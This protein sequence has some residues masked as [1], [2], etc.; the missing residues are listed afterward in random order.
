LIIGV[1]AECVY[2]FAVVSCFQ[3]GWFCVGQRAGNPRRR[4]ARV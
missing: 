4:R 1:P 2:S 3:G